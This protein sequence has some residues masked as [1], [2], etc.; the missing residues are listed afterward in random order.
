M[1]TKFLDDNGLLYFW[2]KIKAFF[3]P[4]ASPAFTGTPT[5]PTATSGDSSTQVAFG[6]PNN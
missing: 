5:A 4:L 3:A 6:A 2:Q 1:A